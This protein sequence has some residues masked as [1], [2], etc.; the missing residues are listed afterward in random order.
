MTTDAEKK[1]LEALAEAWWRFLELERQHPDEVD[2]FRSA[3]HRAQDLI[4][5]RVARRADPATWATHESGPIQ[6]SD[7]RR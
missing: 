5:V 2:E 6:E 1:T 4:A 7:A 3:I